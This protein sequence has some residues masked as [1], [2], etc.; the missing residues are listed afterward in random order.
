[1]KQW[2]LTEG[3]GFFCAAAFFFVSSSTSEASVDSLSHTF[4]VTGASMHTHDIVSSIQV[5]CIKKI[6]LFIF[7]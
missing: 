7:K 2:W 4:S 5:S 3:L 1:M 6:P